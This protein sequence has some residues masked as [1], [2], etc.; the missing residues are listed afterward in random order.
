[1]FDVAQQVPQVIQNIERAKQAFAKYG[2]YESILQAD[3][4]PKAQQEL[5]G[6]IQ[7]IRDSRDQIL[8]AIKSTNPAWKGSPSD[9]KIKD[10]EKLIPP[11]MLTESNASPSAIW[12]AFINKN[13]SFLMGTFNELERE[14]V[15][16]AGS[17]LSPYG[18]GINGSIAGVDVKEFPR[19]GLANVPFGA[20]PGGSGANIPSR[21]PGESVADYQAR[22]GL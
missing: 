5:G 9:Q 3:N 11:E 22:T 2:T 15:H 21:R 16:R 4:D 1:V 20:P 14:L 19:E 12:R 13:P 17:M 8:G 10:M 7:A 18:I 6:A